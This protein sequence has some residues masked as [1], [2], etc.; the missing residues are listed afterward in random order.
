MR[1]R[2]SGFIEGVPYCSVATSPVHSGYSIRDNAT[3]VFAFIVG[4]DLNLGIL[5]SKRVVHLLHLRS[6]FRVVPTASLAGH[7]LP[8][9]RG[10]R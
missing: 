4:I 5:H 10:K 8:R 7:R 6:L 3:V 2:A 9:R 1:P